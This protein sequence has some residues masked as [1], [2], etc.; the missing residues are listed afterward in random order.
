MLRFEHVE[1]SLSESIERRLGAPGQQTGIGRLS[2]GLRSLSERSRAS[3]ILIVGIIVSVFP[4]AAG[5]ALVW[6]YTKLMLC[7]AKYCSGLTDISQPSLCKPVQQACKMFHKVCAALTVMERCWRTVIV[8]IKL[9]SG[10]W[11]ALAD[12]QELHLSGHLLDV[13]L[14]Y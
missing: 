4:P 9:L 14:C 2:F 8:V 7:S 1:P 10:C 11:H 5:S 3:G 13:G 12:L 6:Y